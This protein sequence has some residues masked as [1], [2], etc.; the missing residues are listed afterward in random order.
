VGLKDEEA[1]AVMKRDT[2]LE[3]LTAN[4]PVWLKQLARKL[5]SLKHRETP[6][7]SHYLDLISEFLPPPESHY[8]HLEPAQ[9]K[10]ACASPAPILRS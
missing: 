5:L 10:Q 2:K 7:Y 8:V 6:Q 3:A 4:C 1:V 9:Q